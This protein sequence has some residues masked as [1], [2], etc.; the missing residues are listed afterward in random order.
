MP[1]RHFDTGFWTDPLV[2]RA[3][4]DAKLLFAYLPTSPHCNAAGLFYITPETIQND[5]GIDI[6]DIDRLFEA[7]KKS[8][9]WYR[10]EDLVWVKNFIRWQTKSKTFL[11]AVAKALL[12]IQN[13][14]AVQRLIDYNVSRHG[15][16]IPYTYYKNRQARVLAGEEPTEE[17][18]GVVDIDDIMDPK[19]ASL[20]KCYQ[21]NI[22]QVT[23]TI[24]EEL[25]EIE[26]SYSVRDFE[27]V[28]DKAVKASANPNL[29]YIR[30][31][32]EVMAQKGRSPSK[33]K[34]DDPDKYIKGPYGH[35]VQ[36]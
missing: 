31:I 34:R 26:K 10:D 13:K 25:K 19:L 5:T 8:V 17:E 15:L 29:K 14:E 35:M 4:K 2:V 33:G 32:L 11:Q 1:Q 21:G 6:E 18:T 27:E 7:I 36:R 24:L 22:G 20:A 23:T 9:V 12:L 3:E 30:K 16:V 28:V